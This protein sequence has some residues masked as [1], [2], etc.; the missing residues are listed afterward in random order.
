MGI[1]TWILLGAIAGYVA[2]RLVGGGEGILR[3]VILGIV[4][5]L[6][7]GFVATSVFHAGSV[8][9]LNPESILIAILGATAVLVI[10]HALRPRGLA[11][12]HR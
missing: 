11:R 12:L 6:V 4:G 2:T 7:G 5:A 3:T 10:W 9:G 1:I 8:D